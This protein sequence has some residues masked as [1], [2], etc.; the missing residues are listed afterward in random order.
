[1]TKRFC[2]YNGEMRSSENPSGIEILRGDDQAIFR[3]GRLDTKH[4]CNRFNWGFNRESIGRK[5]QVEASAG[6]TSKLRNEAL[7]WTSCR[8]SLRM[9]SQYWSSHL[10]KFG[11][12]ALSKCTSWTQEIREALLKLCCRC[13]FDHSHWWMSWDN[14]QSK[15]NCYCWHWIGRRL[16]F[17]MRELKGQKTNRWEQ[18]SGP[19]HSSVMHICQSVVIAK[20]SL[21]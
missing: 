13:C 20:F 3:N 12:S 2:P 15:S 4:E 7:D 19:P 8:I 6:E 16:E 18:V 21:A 11:S 14:Q 17:Q 5:F 9:S 10:G 1:M